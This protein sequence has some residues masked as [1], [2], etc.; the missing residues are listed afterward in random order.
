MWVFTSGAPED[1][2]QIQPS[3]KGCQSLVTSTTC[4]RKGTACYRGPLINLFYNPKRNFVYR[5]IVG[6]CLRSMAFSTL[7]LKKGGRVAERFKV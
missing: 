4:R 3:P 1:V 2:Y 6:N 5:K 7:S